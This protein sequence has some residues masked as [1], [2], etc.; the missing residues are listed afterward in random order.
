[1]M[2]Y[3]RGEKKES[4]KEMHEAG[5]VTTNATVIRGKED[6]FI[7]LDN[8]KS[9]ATID[10]PASVS[11]HVCNNDENIIDDKSETNFSDVA[12]QGSGIS[13]TRAMMARPMKIAP[14]A[15]SQ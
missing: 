6:D 2:K 10:Y 11:F 5:G 7:E 1:M 9:K 4:N 13:S 15:M 8:L 3:F 12:E 14:K